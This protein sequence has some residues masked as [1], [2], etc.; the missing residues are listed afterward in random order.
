MI[1][2]APAVY[3]PRLTDLG[4]LAEGGL[5]ERLPLRCD[6]VSIEGKRQREARHNPHN[7]HFYASQQFRP[8]TPHHILRR[9]RMACKRHSWRTTS[10]K[11][12]RACCSTTESDNSS[13]SLANKRNGI[14]IWEQVEAVLADAIPDLLVIFDC[15]FAGRLAQSKVRGP[16]KIFD[17]IGST[18]AEKKARGPGRDS[19]T[20]ALVHAL[21]QL[22]SKPD[23]FDLTELLDSVKTYEHFKNTGQI[24]VEGWRPGGDQQRRLKLRPLP[25]ASNNMPEVVV[26]PLPMPATYHFTLRLNLGLSVMPTREDVTT[27]AETMSEMIRSK[28]TPVM[29]ARWG[30]LAKK[31]DKAGRWRTIVRKL[32]KEREKS[33]LKVPSL[34]A[35]AIPGSL[36]PSPSTHSLDSELELEDCGDD[37]SPSDVERPAKRA[38]YS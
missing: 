32:L 8:H 18:L 26:K 2:V 10:R 12:C 38:R 7:R 3:V 35:S 30:V 17:F 23:G 14:I 25:R 22:A 31:E 4:E 36:T 33:S 37:W 28:K 16:H 21:K 29:D 27:L 24:P 6:C 5:R 1:A 34:V 19:F 9:P 13:N 15:C 11:V 20:S